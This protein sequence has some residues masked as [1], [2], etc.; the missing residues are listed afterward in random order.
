MKKRGLYSTT[1]KQP[2]TQK[3]TTKR[4]KERKSCFTKRTNVKIFYMFDQGH[5]SKRV[6][7]DEHSSASEEKK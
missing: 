4:K 7:K 1:Q 2:E 6:V 3:Y 5:V